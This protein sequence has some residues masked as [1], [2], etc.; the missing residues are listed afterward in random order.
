MLAREPKGLL[1]TKSL[2]KST[3]SCG[4]IRFVLKKAPVVRSGRDRDMSATLQTPITHKTP[5]TEIE[6]TASR[7][8]SV[9]DNRPMLETSEKT[10]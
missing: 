9:S 8:P 3:A 4:S 10:M 1:G 2:M 5:S 7:L 6:T